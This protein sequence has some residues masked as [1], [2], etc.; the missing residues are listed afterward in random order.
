[1]SD[2]ISQLQPDQLLPVEVIFNPAWWNAS[3]G[4][5]FDRDF[6]Y[7]PFC[8]VQSEKIMREHLYDRF[9]D[10]GLGEKPALDKPV[11]GPVHLAAGYLIS[12]MLGC[13]I[14]YHEA[15]P[16]DVICA[17]LSTSEI[18]Q[19]QVP[20]LNNNPA[21][22][23]L[24]LLM[25]ELEN[26]YGYIEGDVNW[27]GVL[28]IALDLRGQELYIDFFD[29]PA[30]ADHLFNIITRT[31][32]RFTRIINT[33]TRSSS[34]S[35]NPMARHFQ[36]PLFLH[37]NCSVAMIGRK[38][39]EEKLLLHDQFLAKRLQPY[40]VHH[41]GDNMELLA[42]AYAKICSVSFFD[43]GWGSNIK[44]CRALL[45]DSFLNLRLSPVRL[46]MCSA[47]EIENDVKQMVWMNGGPH[48]AGL[49]CINMDKGTPDSNIRR[50]FA[51]AD[52]LR[53]VPYQK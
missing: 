3:V 36:F 32:V 48:R 29:N 8:R 45:P 53:D 14:R 52:L 40:G 13:D 24:C 16:P 38:T 18:M 26:K 44:D 19:L 5:T 12:E 21:F 49:C 34:I 25:D 41:C 47:S 39:Y 28:N 1:M 6:F 43:V 50:I 37:S 4:L 11:I 42:P 27:S 2:L 15:A 51:T 20:D 46:L 31:L 10:L 17:H 23:Q 22:Q 35:V 30:L 7:N 9:G 33:R